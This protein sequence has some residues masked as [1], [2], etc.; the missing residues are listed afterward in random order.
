MVRAYKRK[1][2]TNYSEEALLAA[3][4]AVK[5]QGMKRAAAAR[6]FNVPATTLFDHISGK[7]T[8]IGAGKPT[9]LSPAE[10]HE[11]VVTLQVLQEIGFGLTKDLVGVV[12]CDYMKDQPM[13]PNPFQQGIPGHDWWWLFM[14]R[15]K[16]QLSIRKPQHLPTNRANAATPEVIG[17]WF[18]KFESVLRR[19]GLADMP[20]EELQHHIWNCDE[21]GFCTAQVCQKIIAKRGDKAVQDT[22]G[23]SGREYFTILGAGSASGVRLP[24]YFVYKGKN[25][26]SRWMTGG[27]AGS[28]YSVSDSGWMEGA[29]FKQWVEKMFLP[30]V[31]HLTSKN[32]VLLIFDGHHSHI[33]FELIELARKNNIHLLCLPP[34][35]THLLQPLDVGVFGPLKQAWKK[36]LKEHQIETCAGT[37]TKEDFPGLISRLWERSFKAAHIKSGF[38]KT[39]LHPLSRD[40]I[41]VDRLT[42]S[43]PFSSQPVTAT[44]SPASCKDTTSSTE[45]HAIELVGTC[46]IGS[47]TTPIRLHLRGYFSKLLQKKRERP[48]RRE[49]KSKT[50]PRFYGEALT[51]DEVAERYA[52]EEAL[53]AKQKAKKKGMDFCRTY[54]NCNVPT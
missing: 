24:P 30:A 9:I 44:G 15:W 7:H 35:T 33:S 28:L 13:R 5:V 25:L 36:I 14:K 43:L 50:K 19:I 10:E 4:Q 26:W 52:E 32:P 8:K 37:V 34:H 12:I 3:V 27:P 45:T 20:P 31:K 2:K 29:N 11:I 38:R 39:G 23:G 21:T 1:T 16:S 17:A 49:D 40:A 18:D 22:I 51:L 41:P 47:T 54:Y 48:T 42:K 53:K 6:K 46:T